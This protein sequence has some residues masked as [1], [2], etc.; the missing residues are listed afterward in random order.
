MELS[1]L[2]KHRGKILKLLRRCEYLH[3]RILIRNP[4]LRFLTPSTG[5][6]QNP[7]LA[8]SK[9]LPAQTNVAEREKEDYC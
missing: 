4:V 2:N 5:P 8:L 7:G 3:L 1:C 9:Y 6:K